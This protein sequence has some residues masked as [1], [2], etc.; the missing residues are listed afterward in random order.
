MI[1]HIMIVG[2]K[3]MLKEDRDF[4]IAQETLL[5]HESRS[6]RLMRPRSQ[7]LTIGPITIFQALRVALYW[8]LGPVSIRYDSSSMI[9]PAGFWA[10]VGTNAGSAIAMWRIE[11][12]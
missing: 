9:P 10:G 12:P 3:A 2:R 8:K 1:H 4:A 5:S 11:M 7:K 6:L